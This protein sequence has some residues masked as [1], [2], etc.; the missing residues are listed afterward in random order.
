MAMSII[1]EVAPGGKMDQMTAAGLLQIL[2]SQK[3]AK[4]HTFNPVATN[5]R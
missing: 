1:G 5:G 4:I 3:M 2:L